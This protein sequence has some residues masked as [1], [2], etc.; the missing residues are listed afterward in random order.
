M[1]HPTPEMYFFTK[2]NLTIDRAMEGPPAERERVRGTIDR[3]MKGPPAQRERVR[4][5]I[6]RA[7]KGPSAQRKRTR[8]S[9]EGYLTSDLSLQ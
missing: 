5:T 4:G 2:L 3:A 7:T 6:D 9:P 1:D 8:P